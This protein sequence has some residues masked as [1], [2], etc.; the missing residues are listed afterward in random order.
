MAAGDCKYLWADK[1]I[2][3]PIEC[4][5]P[6]YVDNLMNWVESQLND[7]AIF[8]IKFGMSHWQ[9]RALEWR[10]NTAL[11]TMNCLFYCLFA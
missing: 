5:A 6:E 3:K 4:S 7:E 10:R 2:T 8:P 9:P 11:L 1:K